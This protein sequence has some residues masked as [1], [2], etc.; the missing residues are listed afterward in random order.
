[1]CDLVGLLQECEEDT[2]RLLDAGAAN[3]L[4]NW[5]QYTASQ[6]ALV[7]YIQ[8][9]LRGSHRENGW[10]LD[11]KKGLSLERIVIDHCP[12]LFQASDHEEAKRTL[13]LAD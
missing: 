7:A 8:K 13:G 12:H 2:R 3:R 1:M 4:G 10:R 6:D 11:Q 5:R 9:L